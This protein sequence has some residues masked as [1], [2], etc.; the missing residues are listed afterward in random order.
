MST[1]RL[2]RLGRLMTLPETRGLIIAAAQSPTIR[3]VAQRVAHDRAGLV[4]DLRRPGT[5]RE[6]LLKSVQHPVAG[7]L[8]S[9][10]LL[11]LPGRYLPLGTAATWVARRILGRYIRPTS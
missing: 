5:V 11:F 3:A 10:G 4:R 6:L 9:A 2:A 7:E 1:R 8:A